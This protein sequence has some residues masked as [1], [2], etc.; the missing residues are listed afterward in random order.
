MVAHNYKEAIKAIKSFNPHLAICDINLGGSE[1]GIDW[2]REANMMNSRLEI[3]YVTAFSEQSLV[4]EA[5]STEPFNFIIKPWNEQQIIVTVKMAF[6]YIVDQ[7]TE[8]LQLKSLS[9]TEYKILSLISK[10][11]KS[12]EIAE[13]LFVSEKTIRNH[14]YNIIKKLNLPNENNSLLKWA[15]THFK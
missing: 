6:K 4:D 1:T 14:R 2:A 13:I 7:K 3:I 10:Q 8:N 5:H 9:M 12:K 11:K 15:I